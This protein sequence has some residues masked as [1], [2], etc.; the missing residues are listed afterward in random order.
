MDHRILGSSGILVSPVG[1]GTWAMGGV[2]WGEADN[3]LSVA[4]IRAALDAGVTLVDTAPAYGWGRAEEIVGKAIR[5]RRDGIVIATKCGLKPAGTRVLFDLRP[6]EIRKELEA[7]LRR[8]GLETIDLYQCHWPDLETPLEET[9]AELIKMR[10]EGKIRAIGVSNF[11]PPLLAR[12]LATA[13]VVCLQPPYSL[14]D[15]GIEAETLPF[16]R[17]RNL[18]VISY[19]TLGSGILTGKYVSSPR[20][21]EADCRSFFYPF[22]R[23][24]HWG[25]AQALLAEMRAVAA[26]RGRPVA[27]VAVNWVRQQEGITAALVGARTPAQAVEN[28]GALDWELSAG[29]RAAITAACDRIFAAR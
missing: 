29:E 23:E 20:F 4:A 7:S 1:I 18:G 6:A 27:Q 12:A 5:G 28:A 21:P 13:S 17:A 19:G 8:L 11:D 22:Y 3:A 10:D 14:L 24:P 9:M 26:G 2:H 16:C 25:R 15:R